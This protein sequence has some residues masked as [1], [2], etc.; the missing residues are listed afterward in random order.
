MIGYY[1]DTRERP[2][3]GTTD[4]PPLRSLDN[5]VIPQNAHLPPFLPLP[6]DKKLTELSL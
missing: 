3:W 4:P 6:G 2:R 1:V 5:E